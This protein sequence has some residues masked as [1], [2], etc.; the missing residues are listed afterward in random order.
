MAEKICFKTFDAEEFVEALRD[1]KHT[2]VAKAVGVSHATIGK[3]AKGKVE[4]VSLRIRALVTA[5][6]SEVDGGQ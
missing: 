3:L 6:F 2:A 5:Y 4:G 1:R